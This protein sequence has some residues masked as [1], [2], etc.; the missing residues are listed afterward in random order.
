MRRIGSLLLVCVGL[1]AAPA[2]GAG[3]D[4]DDS[5]V[6]IRGSD[7]SVAR[8]LTTE[9]A[10]DGN[11]EVEIVRIE[12]EP[13]PPARQPTASAP[14]IVV[15]YVPVEPPPAPIGI[16]LGWAPR[17]KWERPDP[18]RPDSFPRHFQ[19]GRASPAPV[20]NRLHGR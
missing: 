11:A 5:V 6:V 16:P 2:R 9:R 13:T 17:W 15:V 4:A 20:R 3:A 1:A 19:T 12:T 10:R 18:G 14:Q 7:V 8:P